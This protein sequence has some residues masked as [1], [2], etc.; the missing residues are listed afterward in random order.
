MEDDGG[1]WKRF[2]IVKNVLKRTTPTSAEMWTARQQEAIQLLERRQD[3][4]ATRLKLSA[5][6]TNT[7][8]I[9][10][11]MADAGGGPSSQPNPVTRDMMDLLLILRRHDAKC[12]KTLDKKSQD[13]SCSG[14]D[15]GGEGEKQFIEV[16][17]FIKRT[18]PDT[19]DVFL[20]YRCS[21]WTRLEDIRRLVK[22]LDGRWGGMDQTQELALL[23]KWFAVVESQRLVETTTLKDV[24]DDE[25]LSEAILNQG[26]MI[27]V[28]FVKSDAQEGCVELS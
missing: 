11:P 19:G 20:S 17:H 5:V 26:T 15:E 22:Q 21:V 13:N 7:T 4:I 28:S 24:Q 18:R 2:E 9:K 1:T 12:R 8:P 10:P 3:V 14:D 25:M 23:Y 16:G 27:Q 6:L